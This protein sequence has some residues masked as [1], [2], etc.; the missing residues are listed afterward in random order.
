MQLSRKIVNY[1]AQQHSEAVFT[2]HPEHLK[3]IKTM[4]AKIASA[5]GRENRH[6][7]SHLVQCLAL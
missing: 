6:L 5:S 1:S 4:I 2:D 3:S 7:T